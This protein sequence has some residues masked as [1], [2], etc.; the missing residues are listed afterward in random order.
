MKYIHIFLYA[1]AVYGAQCPNFCSSH[2]S[3]NS[4]GLCNC[5][6]GWTEGDCSART[7]PYGERIAD[8]DGHNEENYLEC[9]GQGHCNRVSGECECYPG[10][11]G[12]AC[13]RT[14]CVNQ[15]SGHGVCTKVGY[16]GITYNTYFDPYYYDG[17]YKLSQ[18]NAWDKESMYTCVCDREYTGY[19][20]SLSIY[21]IILFCK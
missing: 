5:Y 10:Y 15:C 1:L 20:C 7:C 11:A 19:D 12:S 21:F 6:P 18:Y 13:H 9:S 14:E 17:S 3:C 8:P 4:N 16:L 2:G